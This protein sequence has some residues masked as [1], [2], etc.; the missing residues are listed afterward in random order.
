MKKSELKTGMMVTTR[1]G[2]KYLVFRDV[3][4][5]YTDD[6]CPKHENEGVI[7]GIDVDSWDYLYMYNDDLTAKEYKSLD[8]M[9][10]EILDHPYDFTRSAN[11][12]VIAETV[13]EREDENKMFLCWLENEYA[14]HFVITESKVK[15]INE[16]VYAL[17]MSEKDFC[18]N[19]I[20]ENGVCLCI[21]SAKESFI[22]TRYLEKKIASI[23]Y[24]IEDPDYPVVVIEV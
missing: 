4:S 12:K 23:E 8:I 11:E 13:F 14:K 16:L 21:P 7:V 1:V 2:H 6:R 5:K 10:V 17:R 3:K 18:I 24:D 9:K 15:S 20:D 22:P 19:V